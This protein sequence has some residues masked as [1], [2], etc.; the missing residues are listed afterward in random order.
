[1]KKLLL[2][3]ILLSV[4]ASCLIFPQTFYSGSPEWLV[5]MFFNKSSFPDK[6]NY[7][8]GELLNYVDQ[9]TIGEEHNGEGHITFHQ[10]KSENNSIVFSVELN[11][12]GKTINFYCFLVKHGT[13]WKI[14]AVR[15]FV[16]PSFIYFVRDSLAAVSTLSPQDST[17]YLSLK[18]FTM[19]DA[20]LKTFLQKNP[21]KFKELINN[22]R[23]EVNVEI[24]KNLASI[25][26]NA[27]YYDTK[28]PGSV[29]I[30]IQSF[31]NLE[32]GFIYADESAALPY[33]SEV[34]Y[35]FIEEVL[36][37]WYIFRKI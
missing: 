2:N 27:I 31:E 21:G 23:N 10:I 11:Q 17:F 36:N 22:F 12:D 16:L 37:G 24:D 6:A 35:I 28:Y 25:G 1:V 5:D 4:V 20:E 19:S 33:I 15:S 29:F 26:C 14:N 13:D 18:L 8:S 9:P 34:D 3:S 32:S 30:Q 7:F